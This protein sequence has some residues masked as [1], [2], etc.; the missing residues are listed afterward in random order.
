MKQLRVSVEAKGDLADI[1]WYIAQDNESAAD[2]IITKIMEKFDE[3]LVTPGIGRARTELAPSLRSI[4]VGKYLIFY[5]STIEGIEIVPI[6]HGAR[7][8]QSLFEEP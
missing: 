5:R 7:D 6:I 8:I 2:A 4:A 3:L 1:W